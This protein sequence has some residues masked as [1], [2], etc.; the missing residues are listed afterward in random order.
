L[1]YKT[2]TSKKN[3][4]DLTFQNMEEIATPGKVGFDS[5]ESYLGD[6]HIKTSNTKHIDVLN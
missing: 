4:D 5:I 1:D 6:S 2:S 3:K